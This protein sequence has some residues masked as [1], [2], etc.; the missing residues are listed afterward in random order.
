MNKRIKNNQVQDQIIVSYVNNTPKCITKKV[1]LVLVLSSSN[2]WQILKLEKTISW[3]K[4]WIV[5]IYTSWK[6]SI[7]QIYSFNFNVGNCIQL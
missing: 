5:Y 1:Y 7:K 3:Y 6:F 4:D 2:S